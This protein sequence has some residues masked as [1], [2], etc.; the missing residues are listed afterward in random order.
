MENNFSS[1]IRKI[2][3][4]DDSVTIQKVVNLTFADEGVDVITVSDGDAAM[5]KFVEEKPDLVLADVNMPG[6]D[7]YRIC[8]KIK[9]NSAT[10]DIPVIL[11]VGSFE[12]FSEEEAR[13]VGADDFL[14]KPFQSIRQLVN[15]VS[16]LLDSKTEEE[17]FA[18]LD[19]TAPTPVNSFDDTLKMHQPDV[20]EDNFGDSG[21]DD[22]MIQTAQVGSLPIDEAKKYES[23]PVDES[24]LEEVDFNALKQ[25]YNSPAPSAKFE[26]ETDWAKTQPLSKK[27]L[28]EI[29][30]VF[31]NAD[32]EQFDEE[33]E[34]NEAVFS[35]QDENS[36][37]IASPAIA[38]DLDFDDFNLLDFPQP[39]RKG[40]FTETDFSSEAQKESEADSTKQIENLSPAMIDAIAEKVVEKLSGKVI[41]KIVREVVAQMEKKK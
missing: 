9:Q 26:N 32:A 39:E 12:P 22:E 20:P 14:T 34:E 40:N 25:P 16:D 8:E 6:L 4:A 5:E 18:S 35:S 10:K 7:G 28:E 1:S 24:L 41:K 33:V 2:L 15:K 17:V 23:A 29:S 3:L 27:D 11:L 31:P 13:R 36:N 30:D 38:S 19:I 21:M 37:E